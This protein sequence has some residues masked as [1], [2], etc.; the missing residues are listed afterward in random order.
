MSYGHLPIRRRWQVLLLS[1]HRSCRDIQ[2]RA[3]NRKTMWYQSD[4]ILRSRTFDSVTT[5]LEPLMARRLRRI[6]LTVNTP[7]Y[8]SPLFQQDFYKHWNEQ[9]DRKNRVSQGTSGEPVSA[10]LDRDVSN[11]ARD[12]V[13]DDSKPDI[14]VQV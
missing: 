8:V 11:S 10:Q 4:N 1:N 7:Q 13:V 2:E 12:M 5:R 14:G 3:V 9:N 6:T